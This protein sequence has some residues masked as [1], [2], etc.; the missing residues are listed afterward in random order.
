M[1]K[2]TVLALVLIGVLFLAW[3]FL[4]SLNPT[5]P[6]HASKRSDPV[7]PDTLRK[8]APAPPAPAAVPARLLPLQ[9][10]IERPI[11]IRT[12]LYTATL[13]NKGGLLYRFELARYRSW[14]GAP[15]QLIPDDRG[16]AGVLGVTL[17]GSGSQT[18]P[19]DDLYF[20]L[21]APEQSQIG[22]GDSLV[23][24]ARLSL[25]SADSG[26]PAGTLV[27]RYV[28]RGDQYGIGLAIEATG[29]DQ[30]VAGGYA[31]TWRRGLKYQEL[32]SV[33]ESGRAKSISMVNEELVELDNSEPGTTRSERF[34]GTVAWAG[35]HTK[36][37]GAALIPEKPVSGA[38]I[39]ASGR[40]MNADSSGIVELYDVTLKIPPSAISSP[41]TVFVGPLEHAV[42]NQYDLG[43][44]I[45][46]GWRLII[47]PIGEF[48][49]LPIFRFLHGFIGNYGL[50]IIAFSIL[51]RLA[52]WPLSVPQMKSARRM[53]LLQPV[54]AEVREKYK[55]D[56]QR[57]QMETMKIYREYGVNPVGGCLPMLLQMPILYALWGTLSSA[58]DLRQAGFALWITDLS[59]PDYIIPLPISIPLL[60]N[61]IAGL[62]L[63]MGLTLFIQQKMMV[64]DPR[65]KMMIYFLPVFL[66][67]TFNF[68]PSGLNLYYFTFNVVSIGQQLYYTKFARNQPTLEQMKEEARNKKKGWLASKM[69]EAQKMAEQQQRMG[70]AGRTPVEPR[71]KK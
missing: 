32:N 23:V 38:E 45:D 57:Q 4:N 7:A 24:M 43:P 8:G 42:T 37:F 41:L 39:L 9:K 63:L 54:I 10:G 30:D 3:S 25:P 15:S 21:D 18:I 29:L 31:V 62:A 20:T 60:G 64:T 67:L 40:A 28:F 48:F 34:P 27:K 35:L 44:M 19:T 55:D 14:Y 71:K 65:Q 51:I 52:L 12:P 33:D 6:T 46:M 16:F 53:Q 56:S 11:T 17:I 49:M 68:L 50:V 66:T 58:I 69:E 5:K 22:D 61:K 2:R 13:N 1:D 36:Y 26:A 59:I 70:T 47:R